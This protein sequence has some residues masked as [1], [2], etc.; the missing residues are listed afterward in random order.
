MIDAAVVTVA[1]AELVPGQDTCVCRLSRAVI[2]AASAVCRRA[3]GLDVRPPSVRT[4]A[5][6]L[7]APSSVR[8]NAHT[9]PPRPPQ[10]PAAS[11]KRLYRE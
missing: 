11:F 10:T 3:L 4:D 1:H 8:F 6:L 2:A 7:F 5:T 9:D